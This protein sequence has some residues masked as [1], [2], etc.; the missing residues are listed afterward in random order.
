VNAV[1]VAVLSGQ[2]FVVVVFH[3]NWGRG[4]SWPLLRCRIS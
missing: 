1:R 3:G 2:I 4:F